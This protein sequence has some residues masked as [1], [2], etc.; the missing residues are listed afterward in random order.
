[1]TK[2]GHLADGLLLMQHWQALASI[3]AGFDL[4]VMQEIPGNEKLREERI[5]VFLTMLSNGTAEGRAWSYVH[6]VPSGK[7][8][9]HK[10]CHVAFVRSPLVI[11]KV[12][13]WQSAGAAPKVLLDYAPLQI[14]VSDPNRPNFKLCL[15][16]VHLPPAKPPERARQRDT[17]LN[18]IL[19]GYWEEVRANWNLAHTRKGAKDAGKAKEEVV[20]VIAGDY[21]VFPGIVDADAE[22]TELERF[23]L[24]KHDFVFTVPETAATSVGGKNYDNLLVDSTSYKKYLPNGAVMRLV[25]Q[26][27]SA[28]GQLGLSDHNPVTLTLEFFEEVKK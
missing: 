10:E 1:M 16:S 14:L 24:S 23:H 20:H 3:M 19:R 7:A 15:T 17:Q 11:E 26:Q 13:T 9:G 18:A 12:H 6:S 27:N 22:G 25:Q 2:D 4:I 21:N 5:M 8:G 28:K